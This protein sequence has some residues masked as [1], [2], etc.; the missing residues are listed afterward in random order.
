MKYLRRFN[1]NENISVYD[2]KWEVFLPETIVVLKGEEYGI[3]RLVYKKGNVMLNSDM[4]QISYDINRWLAPDTF[5]IDIYLV[6]DDA[7]EEHI[8]Q[9]TV[10]NQGKIDYD[11]SPGKYI[12]NLR[13]DVD[14]TFGDMMASEFT[15]SKDGITIIQDTSYGSK[16]DPTNTLFAIE[17]ESLQKLVDFFNRFN[18]GIKLDITDFNF[19]RDI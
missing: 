19:L 9:T 7:G 17:D 6:K 3:D 13:L 2:P 15:I 14:I 5:E 18:I 4:L 10:I 1:E 11:R 12:H 8:D 16:F